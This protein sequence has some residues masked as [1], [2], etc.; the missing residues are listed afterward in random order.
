[1]VMLISCEEPDRASK[2]GMSI[3]S[4]LEANATYAKP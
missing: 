2:N 1:M 4:G 3:E